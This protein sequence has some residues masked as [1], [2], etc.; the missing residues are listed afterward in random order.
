MNQRID[1]RCERLEL[2]RSTC[3][4][5]ALLIFSYIQIENIPSFITSPSSGYGFA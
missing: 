1:E 4:E 5:Y 2:W 3:Y